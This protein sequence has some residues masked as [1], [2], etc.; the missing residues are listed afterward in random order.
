MAFRTRRQNRYKVLRASGFLPFEA[1]ELSRV[2][3]RV[4][5]MDVMIKERYKRY[6]AALDRKLS[7]AEYERQIKTMYFDSKW[8]RRT[9][10]GR[11]K[12]DPWA[13]LRDF[14][15]TY[16]AKFPDYQSPWERRRKAWRN[17]VAKLEATYEKYPRKMPR[18]KLEY[19]PEGGARIVE[20]GA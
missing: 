12:Y 2:A 6:K 13:M 5:Y 9:R 20:E 7:R 15:H 14:E 18:I 10:T 16:R 19:L 1:K 8:R 17:F 11:F 4:P 3:F